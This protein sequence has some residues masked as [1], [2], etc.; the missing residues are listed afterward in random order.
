MHTQETAG[1]KWRGAVEGCVSE[2]VVGCV[3]SEL[4]FPLLTGGDERIWLAS[5]N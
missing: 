4:S 2:R 3:V 5:C 1:S